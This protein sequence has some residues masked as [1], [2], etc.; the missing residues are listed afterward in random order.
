MNFI[1]PIAKLLGEWSY[2]L[3]GASVAFRLGLSMVFAFIIGCERASKR[4]AAGLRTF[5]TIFLASTVTSMMDIYLNKAY[6]VST[7]MLSAATVIGIAIISTNS[8][9][10][11][12]KSQI[13]GLTTSAGLWAS[14]ILGMTIGAGFY[15]VSLIGYIALLCCLTYFPAFEIFLK[16]RSNHFE[17]HLEL[18]SK[19][20]LQDFITTIRKLGLRI[21]DIEANNAYLSSGLAVY[22]VSVTI[23]SAE[24]KKYKTHKE[25]IEAMSTLDYVY[26]IE[27]M[28]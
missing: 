9:L 15:T 20:N 4:H 24:L 5:I 12:S 26:H 28:N 1:D 19:S 2:D 10:F 23:I 16:N 6:G 17:V 3:G 25:I 13:K 8:I 7:A 22:S 27:E 21:D 14:G 18:V 11:S